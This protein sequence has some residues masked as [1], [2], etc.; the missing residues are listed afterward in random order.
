MLTLIPY[1][2]PAIRCWA[3]RPESAFLDASGDIDDLGWDDNEN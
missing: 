2:P 1:C 3:L